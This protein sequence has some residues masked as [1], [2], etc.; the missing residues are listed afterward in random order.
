MVLGKPSKLI[1]QRGDGTVQLQWSPVA[2]ANGYEI[3]MSCPGTA[4]AMIDRSGKPN[5]TKTGLKNGLRYVVQ[6]IATGQ[7]MKSMPSDLVEIGSIQ[8]SPSFE[9]LATYSNQSDQISLNWTSVPTSSFYQ[10]ERC[11]NPSRNQFARL[12]TIKDN[13]KLT[14]QDRMGNW[15]QP[16]CH[17][18]YYRISFSNNKLV[19]DEARLSNKI[20]CRTNRGLTQGISGLTVDDD[21]VSISGDGLTSGTTATGESDEDETNVKKLRSY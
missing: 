14:F 10:I 13:R 19:P 12:T 6:I 15:C 8:N 5:F 9:L 21:A 18:H 7:N 20:F 3:H 2:N 4:E 16:D 1:A 11:D 17:G